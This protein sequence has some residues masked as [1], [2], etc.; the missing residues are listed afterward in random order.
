MISKVEFRENPIG[1][2][3]V[4]GVDQ[5]VMADFWT[6]L[7]DDHPSGKIRQAG[8]VSKETGTGIGLIRRFSEEDRAKIH[9]LVVAEKGER[10]FPVQPGVLVDSDEYEEDDE[11]D[12]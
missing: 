5:E 4:D 7:V 12:D 2:R 9:E 8:Y 10:K 11:E 1:Y 3:Q 6:L